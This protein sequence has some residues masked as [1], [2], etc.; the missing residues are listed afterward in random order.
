MTVFLIDGPS[1]SGK[2][3]LA[4]RLRD[5]WVGDDRPALVHLDDIYPGW[6]GLDAASA[7]IEHELLG[8]LRAGGVPRWRRYDWAAA[9]QREWVTVDP[10]QPL[11]IEGCGALSRTSAALAD[12]AIW[13]ETDDVERKRRA[14]ARDGELY[15]GEWDRW[16]AQWARF[17]AREDPRSRATL[18]VPT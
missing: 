15:A 7:Q 3:E 1:G 8:P 4:L 11:I 18:I 13:V 9:E 6:D 17:V 10:S 5:G 12:V 2:T 16:E 14:L